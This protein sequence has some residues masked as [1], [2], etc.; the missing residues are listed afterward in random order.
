M[1]YFFFKDR[2]NV[3]L[4]S[5]NIDNLNKEI[6]SVNDQIKFFENKIRLL[7]SERIKFIENSVEQNLINLKKILNN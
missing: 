5:Q 6:Y 3:G 1:N 2:L 7:R 4:I